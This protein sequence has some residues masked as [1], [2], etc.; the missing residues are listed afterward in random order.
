[1]STINAVKIL[2]AECDATITVTPEM[3]NGAYACEKC[4]AAIDF[5]LYEP[6]EVMIA[7]HR[8]AAHLAKEKADAEARRVRDTQL[9]AERAYAERIRAQHAVKKQRAQE[10]REKEESN[11]MNEEVQRLAEEAREVINTQFKSTQ[12]TIQSLRV[13]ASM[14]IIG[15]ISAFITGVAKGVEAVHASGIDDLGFD[16]KALL[17]AEA[18][19]LKENGIWSA[20]IGILFYGFAEV[21]KLLRAIASRG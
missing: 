8:L 19:G 5:T 10:L 7:N 1:M 6:L 16:V 11:R 9:Q 14:F 4:G 12:R 3:L 20:A 17:R 13:F 18:A 15:G 21:L 2:C